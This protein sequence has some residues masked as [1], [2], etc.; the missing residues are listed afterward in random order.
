MAGADSMFSDFSFECEDEKLSYRWRESAPTVAADTVHRGIPVETHIYDDT[1]W[2]QQE[3]IAH[4]GSY[5]YP[6]GTQVFRFSYKFS[7]DGYLYTMIAVLTIQPE[8]IDKVD[9]EEEK[10]AADAEA[11]RLIDNML[12]QGGASQ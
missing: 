6:E 5:L 7:F 9:T 11:W 2:Y 10:A 4:N 8:Q 12:D 3:L 1:E